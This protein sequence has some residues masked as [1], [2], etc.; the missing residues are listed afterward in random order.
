MAIQIACFSDLDEVAADA[1]GQLDREHQARLFDRL[2]WYRLVAIHSPP[3]GV[4]LVCRARHADGGAWLFLARN[5]PRATALSNWYSLETGMVRY[6]NVPDSLVATLADHL[7]R[8]ERLGLI[9]LWP[10]R[11]NEVRTLSDA[12]RAAGWWPSATMM[13]TN[14]NI[15]VPDGGWEAFLS[16]RPTRL[17]N[18]IR[19]KDRSGELTFKIL[20][21]F[22]EDAWD[23]YETIYHS[24]W[25][26][27]E[28]S[29]PLLRALARQ[30]GAAG[31]L[32]LGIAFADS[33]P[34]AAQFW[35]VENGVA[36]IHKLAHAEAW[37]SRSPGT[38]L[39]AAMF[40]HAID[41]DRVKRIDFGTGADAYKADWMDQAAPLYRL[42][43]YNPE[44]M[45]GLIEAARDGLSTA[46]R[47][48][49]RIVIR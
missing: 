20:T 37:R 8:K 2:D 24:S 29:P 16:S 13:T 14:W 7:R 36:T 30:E 10:V 17:R 38:L 6:G 27:E 42:R 19:R 49:R 28:G 39:T 1:Q 21:A 3:P 31:A 26:P 9:D 4:P 25:K 44:T 33:T 35:L 43:L 34:V 5:G 47:A 41:C 40:R 11:E 48:I 12:F 23:I 46:G 45:T 15:V 18:T 22:E 32:R